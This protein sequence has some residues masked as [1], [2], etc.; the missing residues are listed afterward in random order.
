MG[1]IRVKQD[2][3]DI[4]ESGGRKYRYYSLKRLEEAGMRRVSRL[5]L[6]LRVVLESLL[7]NYDSFTV[8]EQDINLLADW[9]AR[10][11]VAKEIPFRV[12]RVLMQDFTG[13]PCVV[14]LAAMRDFVSN[15]GLDPKM[16]NPVV[17]VELVVD[18]SVQV[19]FWATPDAIQKNMQFEFQRNRE[20]Y[21]FLKW[22]Q[23]AF[24]NFTLFP[25]GTGIVHQVNLEY[26]GRN[27]M[28]SK[29]DGEDTV[30]FDSLVGTDSHTTMINGLGVLGWGVGGIE[31]EA[32][33][34]GQPVSLTTPRVVGVRLTGRLREGVTAT[35]LVLTLT[36]IFR[37]ENVVDK[38]VEFFGEGVENLTIPDRA[39]VSNMCPE[40][41]ATVALFPVD[42]ET[43]NY[44]RLTGRSEE[45]IALVEAYYKAQ[46]MFGVPRDGS[47][48]YSQIIEI[49]LNK[50][51]PTI[52]GP[53]LPW[54]KLSLSGITS[55]IN[56]MVEERNKRRGY[57]GSFK[58]V[59]VEH[60]GK[61][62]ELRDGDVVIAAIT[63][64][65]NTSNPYLMIGSGLLA[66][67]AVELGLSVPPYVKTSSAPGSRVVTDYLKTS[68]LLRYL[69]SLGFGI[70]GYGCTT[71]IGNSGPLPKEIEEAVEKNDLVVGSV[72]SGNRNFEMRIHKDVRAN[73]LMSPPLVVAYAIAGS[74]LKD[75]S[76]EPLGFASSKPVY[77]KDIWPSSSEIQEV[78]RRAI[79]PEMF[80]KRY[81]DFDRMVPEWNELSTPSGTLYKWDDG[82]TYIQK[83][84]FFSDFDLTKSQMIRDILRAR[85]LLILGDS[86]T[87]DHISPAGSIMPD[88]P[89]GSYLI[90]R[91]VRPADFNSYGSRRGNHEVMMRGTFANTK[92]K[93]LMLPGVEGGYTIHHP[94]GER[95]SVYDA[96]MRYKS[97][98]VPLVVI[99]GKEYGAGSSRDW[100]AKGPAL[101][102]VR[103]VVAQSFER[104]H[105]SNL[106]GMGV[107]PLEFLEGQN[108]VTLGLKGS[109]T[110]DITG[111]SE[112]TTPG[113]TL[114]LRITDERGNTR[115]T[116]VKARLDNQVE[117]QYFKSGG[118][119]NY[120]LR[121]LIEKS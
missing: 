63:S 35:D 51:E 94:S 57:S 18:H 45:H 119:L 12:A 90:Q 112:L 74:V 17:P 92:I 77:L 13:V 9:N 50:V 48:E 93:N 111:L 83:P 70:V 49:D 11:P 104:I 67:R 7:R 68:G 25:P 66:K 21:T 36:D 102:G 5:P 64:C 3:V 78:M 33:M 19:D 108:A 38:F 113:A 22:A 60:G 99:A 16:I 86:V 42:Q 59:M 27:V 39:T 71:C 98:G 46:G 82:S 24:S 95:M 8:T 43:L 114:I 58:A 87:T 106:I 6:S 76:K 1:E 79:A 47:V 32:A 100:A 101:L 85:I 41:G 105:R 23:N 30:Y 97:E 107:L 10:E 89:A 52:A 88:S 103:A 55:S 2:S 62:F 117:V 44:L 81:S 14:D 75:L 15:K 115:E 91:G 72:L 31:A 80:R 73:Y 56:R 28:S 120:V 37:R 96:A 40:Y 61:K 116:K 4:L 54:S 34:L 109:E 53:A 20:R 69:E 84:P 121:T 118:I 65:T 29:I 26:L 110:L